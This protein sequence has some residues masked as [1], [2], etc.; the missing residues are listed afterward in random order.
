VPAV[1]TAVPGPGAGSR[2][3]RGGAGPADPDLSDPLADVT[4]TP[5]ARAGMRWRG[6][7]RS[8]T[9]GVPENRHA[10][11]RIRGGLHGREADEAGGVL[12]RNG[13]AGAFGAM[14]R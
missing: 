7:G 1:I 9:G 11:G 6:L 4:L 14:R 3:A 13:I 12:G 8:G 5:R 2:A 10:A